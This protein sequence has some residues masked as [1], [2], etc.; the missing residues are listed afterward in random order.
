MN[1]Q[2][3]LD[4][5]AADAQASAERIK[6]E[7]AARAD[8]LRTLSRVKIEGLHTALVLK[9]REDGD[10]LGERMVR[11]AGLEARKELLAQKRALLDESFARARASLSAKP[12]AQKRAFFLR[13][14]ARCAYGD[15]TLAVSESADWLD[16]RFVSDA[17]AELVAV[18]KPGNLT[19]AADRLTGSEGILLRRNGTE[20]C[21]TFD[22]MLE[23]ARA[24]MEQQVAATLFVEP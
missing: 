4:Q 16:E 11:M 13:Q 17:N 18:G 19:L 23:E 10:A 1:A 3:I 8:E 7:A 21:C 24:A 5:I 9:A 22:A 12:V 15:E 6:T 20:V 14:I 2:A